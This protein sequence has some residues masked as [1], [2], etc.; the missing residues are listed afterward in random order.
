MPSV[1]LDDLPRPKMSNKKHNPQRGIPKAKHD[2]ADPIQNDDRFTNK[3][4]RPASAESDIRLHNLLGRLEREDKIIVYALGAFDRYYICWQDSQGQYRQG[5]VPIFPRHTPLYAF[6]LLSNLFLAHDSFE[7]LGLLV[8]SYRLIHCGLSGPFV[9][10]YTDILHCFCVERHGLPLALERWLFPSD[11]TKRDLD[12]LQVSLGHNDEFF[13]F[14]KY[15]RISHINTGLRD[16]RLS[17]CAGA[18]TSRDEIVPSTSTSCAAST[19]IV[20]LRRKSHTFSFSHPEAPTTSTVPNN[21]LGISAQRRQLQG[22]KKLRPR[23]IAITGILSLK[24]SHERN[25]SHD[26]QRNMTTWPE[27]RPQNTEQ[28]R[29]LRSPVRRRPL[30]THACVQ[31]ESIVTEEETYQRAIPDTSTMTAA[32]CFHHEHDQDYQND[33]DTDNAEVSKST[34]RSRDSSISVFSDISS[35]TVDSGISLSSTS[36]M[37][38]TSTHLRN[39]I[40]MG[41]MN[42]YFRESQYRLGDSLIRTTATT[43]D[44]GALCH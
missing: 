3:F 27:A 42:R 43:I 37:S 38:S 17:I 13:A 14:D 2:N 35:R 33:N 11:G 12:T 5:Q 9:Y 24:G 31:T 22:R 7:I 21:D 39:P 29:T 41:A 26:S 32:K 28:S 8:S 15:D 30:Y 4:S 16:P 36:T 10:S 34:T 20:Q 6:F 40:N 1:P 19:A 23:S 25:R 18:G 44:V